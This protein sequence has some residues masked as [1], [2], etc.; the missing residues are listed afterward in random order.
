MLR[1]ER[2]VMN[3]ISI[4]IA[5][6][7][8]LIRGPV[9]AALENLALRQQLATYRRER[10]RP[11]LKP[12]DRIFWVWLSWAWRDWR[13]ALVI[14]KPETVVGWHRQG[15]KLYWRWKSRPGKNGRPQ[16][17]RQVR[18]LIRRL[19]RENPTW[20]APRIQSEL[21]LLGH[22]VA[23]STVG[24]HLLRNPLH[25]SPTW[26]TFLKNHAGQLAAID[27]FVVPTATFRVLYV[28][29][30]LSI[31]RRRVVLVNVTANPSAAWTAQQ[32]VEAF[33]YDSALRY[34]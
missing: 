32:I 4:F 1:S 23:E 11:K 22:D 29:V 27:F 20:G 19:S 13:Q 24:K 9:N 8:A 3:P 34:L 10:P 30:V 15:F 21:K 5:F 31:E 14:V 7:R 2:A 17:D 12:H 28:L 25:P 26:K 33:P 6:L 16:I 18:E